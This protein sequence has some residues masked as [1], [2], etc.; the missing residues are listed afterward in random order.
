[1]V[2]LEETKQILQCP[3]CG[4]IADTRP[5]VCPRCGHTG[6][7]FRE[8]TVEEMDV[9]APEAIAHI[10]EIKDCLNYSV[11]QKTNRKTYHPLILV[12]VIDKSRWVPQVKEAPNLPNVSFVVIRKKCKTCGRIYSDLRIPATR[13]DLLEKYKVEP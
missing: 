11:D 3:L 10:H 6:K 8:T 9:V 1:L 7:D 5:D 4:T 13:K 2:E 12:T